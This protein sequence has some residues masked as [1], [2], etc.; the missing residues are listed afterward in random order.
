MLNV[1][2]ENIIQILLN[3]SESCF[4]HNILDT[5]AVNRGASVFYGF[6]Y[7]N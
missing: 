6:R 7:P 1:I 4:L 2:F 3:T 5:A